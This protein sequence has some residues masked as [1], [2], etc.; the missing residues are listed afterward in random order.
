MAPGMHGW[1]MKQS[2]AKFEMKTE[3]NLT[4][5]NKTVT[6]RMAGQRYSKVL[7]LGQYPMPAILSN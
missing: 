5:F 6:K 7:N 3:L 1:A 2:L 4:K